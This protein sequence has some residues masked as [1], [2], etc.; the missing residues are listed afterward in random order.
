MTPTGPDQ[1]MAAAVEDA[2]SPSWS[3]R[4]A[5]GRRLAASVELAVVAEVLHRLLLDAHDSAVTQETAEAL[6]A[7]GDAPGLRTVL[8]AL[9]CA[10]EMWTLDQLSAAVDCDPHWMTEEGE[11]RLVRQLRELTADDDAGVRSEAVRILEPVL[12]H[13]QSRRP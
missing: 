11:R 6:L 8:A 3:V 5:A 2:D 9:S 7:R 10:A 4:A 12:L 1:E 13:R